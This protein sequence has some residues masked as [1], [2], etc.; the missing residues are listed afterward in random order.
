MVYVSPSNIPANFPTFHDSLNSSS[1]N[2]AFLSLRLTVS[3]L[4]RRES[5]DDQIDLEMASFVRITVLIWADILAAYAMWVMVTYL[6]NVWKLNFVHAAGI[7]NICGGIA[8]IMPI[9]FAFLVDTVMGDYAMLLL[10]SI[11]YSIGLSFLAMSTP[12]VLSK[13]TGTCSAYRPECIGDTQRVLFYTALALIAVGISGHLVSLESFLNESQ[14]EDDDGG[15]TPWKIGGIFGVVLVPIIG[16]IALPYIKPW[17]IRFGIPAIFSLVATLLFA[18]GSNAYEFKGPQGSPL[19]TVVR[20]FV[21]SASKIFHQCPED[22]NE[23][24]ERRDI[25]Q[26]VP[27]TRGLRC[28]D[29]AATILPPPQT[30]EEQEKNRWRLCSVTEVEETKIGIRMVPMWLTFIICGVV[31]SIGNTYFLEQANHMN[32]KVGHL[33]VPLPI[34]LMFYEFAKSEFSKIYFN[35][36]KCLGRSGSKRYAPPIGIAVAMVFSVL[37]CIT[38]AKVETRRLNVIRSHDLVDKPDKRIPMSIFWLLPQFLLLGTLHGICEKSIV[39]FFKD[40]APPSMRRYLVFFSNGVFGL[41]SMAS[42]LSV[43]IVGKFSERK[44]NLNWFQDTLNR[45]RL[46]NYY[47]TLAVLSTVNLVFYILVGNVLQL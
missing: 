26:P 30:Q 34:F 44:G 21:A 43:Y 6:T 27:H 41:G 1:H 15:K 9:G 22:A 35:L 14:M 47:W 36:A 7:I 8:L 5:E 45:S 3:V 18:S 28:L 39:D 40:Q 32:R 11:A 29:K 33:K 4:L 37:C 13:S 42:V 2:R 23:L 10:S 19:T 17:S 16:G 46:D 12:P 25:V 38:A 24:Y 31:L 20:V